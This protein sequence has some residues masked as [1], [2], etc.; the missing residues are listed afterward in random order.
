M[1][2]QHKATPEQWEDQERRVRLDALDD[3]D[4]SCI[5]ELRARVES[6]EAAANYPGKPDSSPVSAEQEARNLAHK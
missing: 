1:S 3:Q 5:L 2:E 6:L 4:A